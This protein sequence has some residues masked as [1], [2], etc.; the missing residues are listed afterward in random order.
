MADPEISLAILFRK[1]G[2]QKMHHQCQC[3]C[4]GTA[5]DRGRTENQCHLR[6]PCHHRKEVDLPREEE[7]AIRQEVV[8]HHR[9]EAI[10]A[11]RPRATMTEVDILAVGE[12]G[13]TLPW[14]LQQRQVVPWS[15]VKC[16]VALSLRLQA[17]DRHQTSIRLKANE[18]YPL[19]FTHSQSHIQRTVQGHSRRAGNTVAEGNHPSAVF[20]QHLRLLRY[21]LDQSNHQ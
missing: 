2:Y 11:R 4:V 14:A 3:R 8:I 6:T 5:G 1:G 21:Q 10:V 9:E 15:V 7:A 18:S 12:E 17:T 13:S 16:E 19:P 20:E